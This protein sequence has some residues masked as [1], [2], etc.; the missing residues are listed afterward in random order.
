M[1]RA[2]RAILGDLGFSGAE[3]ESLLSEGVTREGLKPRG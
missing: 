1:S 3:V 2:T